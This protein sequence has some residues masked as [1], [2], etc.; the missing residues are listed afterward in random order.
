MGNVLKVLMSAAWLV[1]DRVLTAARGGTVTNA[2]AGVGVGH[3]GGVGVGFAEAL[4]MQ[5]GG[6]G[7]ANTGRRTTRTYNTPADQFFQQHK[8]LPLPSKLHGVLPPP[9]LPPKFTNG[10]NGKVLVIGDVHGCLDE[11]QELV[12]QAS[13]QTALP[14]CDDDDNNSSSKDNKADNNKQQTITASSSSSSAFYAIII[15][16]DLVNKGPNSLGVLRYVQSQI[17][18]QQQQ[19][20]SATSTSSTAWLCIRGNHDNAALEV[21]L[22]KQ[23]VKRHKGKYEWV[24]DSSSDPNGNSNSSE[25]EGEEEAKA[26]YDSNNCLTDEDVTFLAELPYTLS[27]P[28]LST[29]CSKGTACADDARPDTSTGSDDADAEDGVT[30]VEGG[31][32]IVH[33]GLVPGVPLKDQEIYD[34]ITLRDVVDLGDGKYASTRSLQ[35]KNKRNAIAQKPPSSTSVV[36]ASSSSS[37]PLRQERGAAEAAATKQQQQDH[38]KLQTLPW[39]KAWNGPET[40][41]FGHDAKRELQQHVRVRQQTKQTTTTTSDTGADADV[42]VDVDVDCSTSGSLP[43]PMSSLSLEDFSAIGLDT[44]AVYGKKLT[45]IILP[46]CTLVSVP[47]KR[48]YQPIKTNTN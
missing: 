20:T 6:A 32:R 34:L 33:A 8:T 21:A 12:H 27:I 1:V 44:G 37:S 26:N 35:N 48:V 5:V 15:V 41:I 39:A 9:P 17:Q 46:D 14:L 18:Q 43:T 24:C 19:G 4:Q 16:G 29:T 31:V 10:N 22:N 3:R 30:E 40:V 36:S 25:G 47:S 7:G 45:G 2:A 42:D 11:L 13:Q 28:W 23:S 38:D